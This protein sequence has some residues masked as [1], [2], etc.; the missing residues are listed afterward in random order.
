M[1]RL[2]SIDRYDRDYDTRKLTYLHSLFF[3]NGKRISRERFYALV[4]G[5]NA[6]VR[7]INVA[8]AWFDIKKYYA[9]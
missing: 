3:F 5:C 6:P 1:D 9:V 7:T 2:I 4:S 8:G